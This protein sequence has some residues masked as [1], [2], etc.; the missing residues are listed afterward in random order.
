MLDGKKKQE[1]FSSMPLYSY[2]KILVL[3]CS[4]TKFFSVVIDD[5]PMLL[6]E[7]ECW[8]VKRNNKI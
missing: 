6:Y 5:S 2:S 1:N 3:T 7:S 4:V 8:M